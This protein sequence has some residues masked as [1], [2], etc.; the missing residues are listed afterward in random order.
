MTLVDSIAPALGT[1]A[2]CDNENPIDYRYDKRYP[3]RIQHN[4]RAADV[5]PLKNLEIRSAEIS[6][7]RAFAA[8]VGAT[9]VVAR[10]AAVTGFPFVSPS[11]RL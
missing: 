2:K 1:V 8:H 5:P 9:L 4:E 7:S 3:Y 11:F 6:G 10:L